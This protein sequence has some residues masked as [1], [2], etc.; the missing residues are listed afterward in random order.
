M[1]RNQSLEGRNSSVQTA[2]FLL[3][4]APLLPQLGKRSTEVHHDP[5][6]PITIHNLS[7]GNEGVAQTEVD[8]NPLGRIERGLQNVMLEMVGAGPP[9][10]PAH[11][12]ARPVGSK[13]RET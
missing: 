8:P 4:A 3:G 6:S 13:L 12:P 2:E 1:I 5:P 11:A 10:W 9:R 7:G